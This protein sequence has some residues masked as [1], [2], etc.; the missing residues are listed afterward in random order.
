[1]IFIS[2]R[3]NIDGQQPKF[4]NHPDYINLAISHNF[5]VEID[6]WF[7]NNCFYL[8]HDEPQYE[9]KQNFLRNEKLWCH[10]KNINAFCL[11]LQDH[12]IHCFWH[13]QDIATLTSRRYIWIYP[14]NTI[15]PGSIAVLPEKAPLV[16]WRSGAG[17][18]SDFIKK[19][20]ISYNDNRS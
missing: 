10:A 14:G 11:M 9:I 6:V 17:V 18:C 16:E 2:H 8:G 7:I 19:Y 3:G 5:C 12:A 4:E 13:D 20:Q 1:M 15:M